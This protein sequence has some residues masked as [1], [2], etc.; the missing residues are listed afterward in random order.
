MCAENILDLFFLND[1][2]IHFNYLNYVSVALHISNV[3]YSLIHIKI[4]IKYWLK[5]SFQNATANLFCY[6][7]VTLLHYNYQILSQLYHILFFISLLY[8]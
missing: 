8:I 3:R 7:E 1:Q 6:L 5:Q 4:T 2:H